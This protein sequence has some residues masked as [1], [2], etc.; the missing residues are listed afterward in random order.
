MIVGNQEDKPMDGFAKNWMVYHT[1]LINWVCQ[2]IFVLCFFFGMEPIE[3]SYS[4]Y[5]V[6]SLQEVLAAAMAA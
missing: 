3:L 1:Q 6:S 2:I 5:P 4:D